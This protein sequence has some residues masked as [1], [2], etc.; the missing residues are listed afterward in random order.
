MKIYTKT[1]DQGETGLFGGPRVRKDHARIRAY[2]EV[3]ELNAV[4][5]FARAANRDGGVDGL[6]QAIQNDLF[7]VGA[8]LAA[9]DPEKLKG[10]GRFAGA[11]EVER[12]EREIDRME[13]D[14]SPLE[15]F[16]LPGGSELAARLHLART[17][18]RR[19]E[20]EV[21]ALAASA[22]GGEAV[23]A[24]IV[25]YMNRLSDFLFVLAR[26]ANLKA[27]V[28]DVPWTKKE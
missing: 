11:R 8:V 14:L 16:I 22:K 5:G 6:L 28:A 19:A 4:V 18:C 2:G 7:D 23:G 9:P 12:L 21:V 17:V 26:W 24:E 27:G 1:G 25:V 13:K 3:D 10:K 20:R 15:T